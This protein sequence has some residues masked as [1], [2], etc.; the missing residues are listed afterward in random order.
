MRILDLDVGSVIPAV[1]VPDEQME[2]F[3]RK[4]RRYFCA[5]VE[6]TK[7]GGLGKVVKV[8]NTFGESVA[9]KLLTSLGGLDAEKRS[10]KCDTFFEEYR[11]H[12]SVNG[13]YGFPLLYGNANYQGG[14]VIIMEWVQG[15]SLHEVE[16]GGGVPGFSPAD[17]ATAATV[18]AIGLEVL[19]ILRAAN[20]SGRRFIHRDI[21]PK[22]IMVCEREK[23]V[24]QQAEEG[25]FSLKLIDFGSA[26][27][28]VN[29][30]DPTFTVAQQLMRWGTPIYAAP[31]MLTNDVPAMFEL[32]NRTSVD[33]YALASVLY[34][35]YAA[36]PPFRPVGRG[37]WF[38]LKTT[39]APE[40]LA[41]KAPADQPVVD[42]IMA[43]LKADA[44]ERFTLEQLYE[45]LAAW[46][47]QM[48]PAAMDELDRHL[49]LAM[50]LAAS[51]T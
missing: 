26:E 41:S 8:Y 39:T 7:Q 5:P 42:A 9:L 16:R 13:L 45:W 31:E 49:E 44:A 4:Y 30:I 50:S 6:F 32:R 21:S 51:H 14:P 29:D 37:S 22:N 1:Y 25:V 2:R 36:R 20:S 27:V 43:C 33:A 34:E 47:R 3:I 46:Y 28:V 15:R 40:P 11:T 23:N 18:A 19:I 38:A 17:G 48:R 24:V 10:M 12:A 35:L